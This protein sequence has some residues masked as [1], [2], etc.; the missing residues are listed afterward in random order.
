[1]FDKKIVENP[2]FMPDSHDIWYCITWKVQQ[3]HERS[4]ELMCTL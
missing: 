1:M 3:W 2:I 4:L